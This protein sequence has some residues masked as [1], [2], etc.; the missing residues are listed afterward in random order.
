[1]MFFRDG[2]KYNFHAVEV[3][4]CVEKIYSL[5]TDVTFSKTEA[6]PTEIIYI[7]AVNQVLL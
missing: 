5:K 7:W 6:K 1:M 3:S 2:L 4:W